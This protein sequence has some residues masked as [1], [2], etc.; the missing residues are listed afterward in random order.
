VRGDGR[1]HRDAGLAGEGLRLAGAVVLV[2]DHAGHADV[3]TELAEVLD[4]AA[5]VVGHV[6]AL[7]VVAGHDDDL[8]AHVARNRQ[9]EAAADHVAQEVEQHVVEAPVVEAE[10]LE[11]LE[12]VDDP[13]A[14][15]AAAHLGP[16]EFHRVDAVALEAHV[17]DGHRLAGQLLLR[18]RLDDRGRGL[19]AE[20]QAGGV[21]LR[22]AADQQHLLALLGH[23]VAQVGEREAL[24]DAAL[25][26]DR[27]DLRGLGRRAGGHRIGL[28][29]GFGLQALVAH[30][31]DGGR[32]ASG[33]ALCTAHWQPFQSRTI[34]RQPAS[35]NAVR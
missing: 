20:Q 15:A 30:E 2:D 27:D 9:A 8:L 26:V 7:Q 12:A 32:R 14:T 21:A 31:D 35:L 24:A 28:D 16:A 22:I 25:A 23:H 5:H 11:R 4:R 17:A 1:Q 3:A 33:T 18:A 29:R 34:F 6:Q 19:A 10:L 13:A